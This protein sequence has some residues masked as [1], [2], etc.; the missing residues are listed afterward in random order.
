MAGEDRL[1]GEEL[2]AILR[3]ED[4]E[5]QVRLGSDA[6]RPAELSREE[7]DSIL[8]RSEEAFSRKDW[9]TRAVR[10]VPDPPPEPQGLL[11]TE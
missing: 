8:D 11:P 7:I 5:G 6:H 9:H 2:V 4:D 1:I 3:G 10:T